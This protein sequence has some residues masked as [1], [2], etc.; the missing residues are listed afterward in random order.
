[1]IALLL[2]LALDI[3]AC[4]LTAATDSIEIRKGGA[5]LL[6]LEVPTA[7]FA[8]YWIVGTSAGVSP[9]IPLV[10]PN[11]EIRPFRID[12]NWDGERGY[13]WHTLAYPNSRFLQRSQ[14]YLDGDG[15]ASI[16]FEVPAILNDPSLVGMEI[17]HQ[18]VVV[19]GPDYIITGTSNTVG[20]LLL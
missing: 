7:P 5:Q 11:P 18:A 8:Y 16:L 17:H 2:A 20:C 12:L 15:K 4:N 19:V 14:G 9:G 6:E 1:M 10:P 3:G 13:L